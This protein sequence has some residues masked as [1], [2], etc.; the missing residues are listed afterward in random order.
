M[1]SHLSRPACFVITYRDRFASGT[2][3]C[4]FEGTDRKAAEAYA[5]R[6]FRIGEVLSIDF[7]PAQ[8]WSGEEFRW[9]DA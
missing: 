7:Q 4:T 6:N 1:T 8:R 2:N 9:I 5:D 3:C